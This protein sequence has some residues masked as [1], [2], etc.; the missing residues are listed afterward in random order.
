MEGNEGRCQTSTEEA[1]VASSKSPDCTLTRVPTNQT[2]S[3]CNLVLVQKCDPEE[4]LNVQ[5][6]QGIERAVRCGCGDK[7]YAY[8]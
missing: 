8:W 2:A 1:S 6:D 3:D 4:A 7:E 5:A